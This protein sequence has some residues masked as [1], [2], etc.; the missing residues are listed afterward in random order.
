LSHQSLLLSGQGSLVKIEDIS[1]QE[2]IAQRQVFEYQSIHGIQV[3]RASGSQGD[4]ESVLLLIWGG[5]HVA[6]ARCSFE[7]R[8]ASEQQRNF[9]LAIGPEI[10]V[11]DWIL[12]ASFGPSTHIQ[13]TIAYCVTAHNDIFALRSDTSCGLNISILQIASGIKS[14]LCSAHIVPLSNTTVLVA[15]GT[16]YGEVVV[17]ACYRIVGEIAD[18][19]GKWCSR[20]N[21]VFRGHNGSVFGV[22]LS[23][24]V[25][26]IEHHRPRRFLASCSDDR[27]IRIWKVSDCEC[28]SECGTDVTDQQLASANQNGLESIEKSV[29]AS[30]WGHLSR[31]WGVKFVSPAN[32]SSASPMQLIS[33]GEDATCQIWDLTPG[34][35]ASSL[36]RAGLVRQ[37]LLLTHISTDHYHCG[38]HIWS[39]AQHPKLLS[40]VVF[41]GG[42]DGAIIARAVDVQKVNC[43]HPGIKIPFRSL[44]GALKS[45]SAGDDSRRPK[46][47]EVIKQYVFVSGDAILATTNYGQ[48][49]KGTVETQEQSTS[50]IASITWSVLF[51]AAELRAYA[52]MAGDTIDRT[53]Y[54]CSAVGNIWVY[55]HALGSIQR[56]TT[57]NEKISNIFIGASSILNEEVTVQPLLVCSKGSLTAKLLQVTTI[58]R[59]HNS[60]RVTKT[61]DL[62]LSPTFQP[63]AF[64][65]ASVGNV[66]VV[67]SRS[68]AITIYQGVLDESEMGAKIAPAVCVRHVHGADTVTHLRHLPAMIGSKQDGSY[69]DILSTGRDGSYAI[70]RVAFQKSEGRRATPTLTTLHRSCAAF[71]SNIEGANAFMAGSHGAELTFHGFEGKNFV[72][73]NESSNSQIISVACG[74]AHRSWAYISDQANVRQRETGRGGCFVWTKAGVFNMTKFHAPSHR[75]IQSGGHGRE[76]KA[77]ALYQKAF[78]HDASNA[79][80]AR[81]IATGAEDTAIRLWV[82]KASEDQA[83]VEREWASIQ[84]TAS[85]I[86]ILKKHTTGIQHLAFCKGFL[87]SSAGCEEFV[88]WKMN[89][90]VSGVGVGTVFQAALPKSA[91]VSDLRIT[92][93]QVTSN[94]DSWEAEST[95]RADQFIIYAAYSNSMVRVFQYMNDNTLPSE[96]RF[97]LLGEGFYNTRCLTDL[98]MLSG[99]SRWFVTTSTDGAVVVW[100]GMHNYGYILDS[101]TKLFHTTEH[102]IHQNAILALHVV[103]IAPDYYLL[104]TGGDDNA[105]GVTVLLES[106]FSNGKP[107]EPRSDQP[108]P[109]FGTLLIPRAHAAAITALEI[110]DSRNKADH[111]TVLLISAGNDQRLKIWRV[112]INVDELARVDRDSSI[113]T[114]TFGPE[115]VQKIEVQLVGEMWTSVADVSSMTAIPDADQPD[116]TAGV[117]TALESRG[118][119]DRGRG[120]SKRLMVAGIGMETFRIDLDQISG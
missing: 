46:N 109:R 90:E 8:R 47:D 25:D 65:Q 112:T 93:F 49:I 71:G 85:C 33:R 72:V 120:R 68:G 1:E 119:R 51:D 69:Y 35:S 58:S 53:V 86:R 3:Q 97:N 12:D 70:H 114:D 61:C 84:D 91:A 15:A 4:V 39:L 44:F 13:S 45:E 76:I 19:E 79:P 83:H 24:T 99:C 74:G 111:I 28:V 32:G 40:P 95:L 89:F 113:G 110:L 81:L 29:V 34:E 94:Q 102:Y 48:V 9:T 63:T 30:T 41:T 105:F 55:Q 101:P 78:C 107:P 31:I 21:N 18:K 117:E 16:I 2:T 57:I 52:V 96:D 62:L 88:I 82:V 50:P 104:L 23:E 7:Y 77:L 67:G 26:F 5:R 10:Q 43:F 56:L 42:S 103:R 118:G 17:W 27:T 60:I 116:T 73:W 98:C 80:T 14:V 11:A 64:L 108:L 54:L 38:K 87:F 106:A 37:S 20:V 92:S 59:E 66:A 6:L 115:V 75:I 36:E 100:P 22:C